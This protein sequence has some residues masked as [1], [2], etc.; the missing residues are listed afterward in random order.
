MLSKKSREKNGHEKGFSIL[1][2]I[3]S[4][5]VFLIGVAAVFSATQFATIQRNT[6]STRTDQLR[7]VRI[8]LEYIRRDTLNAGFGYHRTGGN[9]QDNVGNGLFGLVSDGDTERDLMTSII[10]GDNR[11]ANNLNFSGQTDVLAMISRDMSFNVDPVTKNPKL[12]NYTGAVADGASVKITTVTGEAAACNKYDLYML[13]SQSGTTQV[14]GMVTSKVN[15]STLQFARTADDPFGINQLA[16]GTGQNQSLLVTTAG[17]GT[18]KRLN[19]V[20]YSVTANGVL[21][22]KRYGNRT[23]ML[24]TEQVETRELVYGVSDFQ[25]KYFMENGTT[26]DDPSN[27]NNGRTNQLKMNGIVQVQVSITLATEVDGMP[28]VSTPITIKE[29]ISTKNLRYESS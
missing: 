3:V 7:S 18:I 8:A 2:L 5:L 21:V 6:I 9:S 29:Y 20:S 4:M 27:G 23:G 26:V 16:N 11:N 12:V 25:V 17:G 14:V 1:E 19:M 22:R 15:N 13:E 28:R 10:A 24:S